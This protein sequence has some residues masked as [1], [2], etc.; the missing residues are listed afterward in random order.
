SVADSP[1]LPCWG[2]RAGRCTVPHGKGR[3]E[4]N[5]LNSPGMRHRRNHRSQRASRLTPGTLKSYFRPKPKISINGAHGESSARDSGEPSALLIRRQTRLSRGV[6]GTLV[7][8]IIVTTLVTSI[9][10][11]SAQNIFEALFG[12]LWSSLNEPP[13]LFS[14]DKVWISSGARG[15]DQ[16]EAS[17]RFWGV[18]RFDLLQVHNLISWEEHLRTLLAMKATGELRYVGITTS[19]GRRHGEVE[20]IMRAQPLD[21]VQ[22]TYNVLDRQVEDRI[23]PLARDRGIGVIANRPF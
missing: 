13:S 17:R 10:A 7:T 3:D 2:W 18:S 19:E 15:A 21:F 1:C 6:K 9:A 16:I 12:R 8:G 23:L 11:A 14:A 22:V 20:R 4:T 5:G